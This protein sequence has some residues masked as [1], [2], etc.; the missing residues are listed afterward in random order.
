MELDPRKGVMNRISKLLQTVILLAFVLFVPLALAPQAR[1]QESG[2][3][4]GD[5]TA[6]VSSVDRDAEIEK[7]RK[8]LEAN[9]DNYRDWFKLGNLY[10]DAG[11]QSQAIDCYE[12]TLQQNPKYVAALVNLGGLYNDIGDTDQALEFLEKALALDPED[13]KARSNLGNVYYSTGRYPDAMFEYLRAVKTDP[14][15]YSSLYNI[16][17]A[18]ADAGMF[19]EAVSWWKKVVE[20]APETEAARSAQENIEI[21]KR[22]TEAP[23]P[24]VNRDQNE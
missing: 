11:K 8:L 14:K 15:C 2:L 6:G 20:V 23:I 1:A 24:P 5:A 9:P 16:G 19:R 22:F 10:Q 17:V 4:G 12:R 13:C 7:L 3:L 18:F 21:L